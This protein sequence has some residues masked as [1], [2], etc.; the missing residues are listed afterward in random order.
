MIGDNKNKTTR[1]LVRNRGIPKTQLGFSLDQ[2]YLSDSNICSKKKDLFELLPP[3]FPLMDPREGTGMPEK[4]N[5]FFYLLPHTP[6]CNVI[7]QWSRIYTIID[8]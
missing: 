4:N 3:I 8:D 1:Q 6:T 7:Q 5:L 2:H